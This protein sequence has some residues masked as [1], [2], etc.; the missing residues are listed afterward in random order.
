[1]TCG[2]YCFLVTDVTDPPPEL[3]LR[4]PTAYRRQVRSASA[5]VLLFFLQH[6]GIPTLQWQKAA[7]EGNGATNEVLHAHMFHAC[8]CWAFKPNCTLTSLLALISYFCTHAKIAAVVHAYSS[9]SLLG[10]IGMAV[11]RLLEYINLLQQRRMN[12]YS[13]FDT[14]LHNT[15]LLQAMLHVDHAYQEATNGHPP[16]ESPV[17]NSMIFQ[18][19]EVQDLCLRLCGSNLTIPDPRNHFW[20]TGNPVPLE[21][22]DYRFR[23]PW[24]WRDRVAQGTSTGAGRSSNRPGDAQTAEAYV[25]DAFANH[26]FN[27]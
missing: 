20:Y 12:A 7:R 3:F 5:T 10:R 15:H 24:L 18:I 16:S 8:R 6:V 11:D 27:K 21:A 22:G 23:K 26:M 2:I 4:N 1:V 25:R 19:R 17:T 14:A 9:V 13:G